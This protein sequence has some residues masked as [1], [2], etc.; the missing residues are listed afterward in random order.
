MSLTNIVSPFVNLGIPK[1]SCEHKEILSVI[2]SVLESGQFVNGPNVEKFEKNLAEYC[3]VT[4]ALGLNSGTDA[5]FFALKSIGITKDDEVIIP[6]NTFWAVANSVINSGAKPVFA[7][8]EQNDMLVSAET[9]E[10]H[11]T[12][13]TKAVIC[14][15]LTGLPCR[16]DDINKL[17]LNHDFSVIEDSAQ[18]LGSEYM[19]RKAGNLGRVG[20]FSFHPLKNIGGVG[21][22]GALVT[23]D[24]KIYERVRQL[25]NH[26][27]A[28]KTSV[29]K[30]VGYNSRLDELQSAVLSYRL[31]KI[32]S[33]SASKRNIAALYNKYLGSVCGVVKEGADRKGVYQL[34]IIQCDRRDELREY[35][36]TNG[37]QTGVHYPSYQHH[38]LPYTSFKTNQ[39]KVTNLLEKRVLSLPIRCD[40]AAGEVER[41]CNEIVSFY[42]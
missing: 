12:T 23:N 20:C 15:H 28:G 5:L 32:E 31:K 42:S 19:G 38:Q 22:G 9:I 34:Y 40:M 27:L 25:R 21:D 3:G 24:R 14:V 1:E 4:Y 29:Q 39:L 11:I 2:S 7:D 8:V 16:M 35:L 6:A 33:I 10:P 18:G 17:A 13:R 36:L 41:I 37:I 26:G 30:I